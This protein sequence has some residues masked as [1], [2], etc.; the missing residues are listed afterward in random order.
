[1]NISTM[2][3]IQH[4]Q[5]LHRQSSMQ[6]HISPVQKRVATKSGSHTHKL[7][8]ALAGIIAFTPVANAAMPPDLDVF[9]GMKEVPDSELGHMRG[10]F[11]SN[12]QV[13]YFGVE[14]VSNWQTAAGNVITA[15]ANLNID[16]RSNPGGTPTVQY[17]PTVSIVQQSQNAAPADTGGSNNVS[18]GAGLANVSGVSQNIQV[19][20]QSNHILNGIDMQVELSSSS[21]GGSIASAVQGHAGSISAA[22]DDG[23][24]ATV[25]LSNNSIG[26]NVNV[27]GQGEILQQIRNQGMFQ[28]ARIGGDLNQI[29]NAI[30][31]QIGL[32]AAAGASAAGAFAAIQSLKS[33]PQNGLF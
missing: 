27:P 26:V 17:V 13:L 25:T 19:A 3:A 8:L 33:L 30:T 4:A 20:G 9:N 28:S 12:N 1:M 24:I 16:F 32:N 2:N 5:Y 11:A 6:K 31:M 10:K 21:Q 14:I 18:G 23:T 22:G 15:G 29:H 7:A